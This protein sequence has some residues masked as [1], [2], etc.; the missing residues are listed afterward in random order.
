MLSKASRAPAGGWVVVWTAES[1]QWGA[2][3]GG[4]CAIEGDEGTRGWQVGGGA[5]AGISNGSTGW[6][7]VI[8]G[9]EGTRLWQLW[10]CGGAR[11]DRAV[12]GSTR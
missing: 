4:R 6:E 7:C 8:E 1:P 11:A 3:A 5:S 10:L 12:S 9:V 2:G